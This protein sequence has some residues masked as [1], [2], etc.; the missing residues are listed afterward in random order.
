M[1]PRGGCCR[2][3]VAT[4]YVTLAGGDVWVLDLVSGLL[5]FMCL[6]DELYLVPTVELGL[7]GRGL[8]LVYHAGTE[9]D[10][11][12]GECDSCGGMVS[13]HRSWLTAWRAWYWCHTT[14]SRKSAPHA[15]SRGCAKGIPGYED[16]TRGGD[17]PELHVTTTRSRILVTGPRCRSTWCGR[18]PSSKG[19][20]SSGA[21]P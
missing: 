8:S 13:C 17:L 21:A 16:K 15:G 6:A 4:G 3:V 20:G 19:N 7:T 14:H 10:W 5:P 11:C 18:P 9:V 1:P 2:F 12:F